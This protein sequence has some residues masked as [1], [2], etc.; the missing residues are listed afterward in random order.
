MT[1]SLSFIPPVFILQYT[2][3]NKT[4]AYIWSLS[5]SK[6]SRPQIS[7]GMG[8]MGAPLRALADLTPRTRRAKHTS[9]SINRS[10][11]RDELVAVSC[12]YFDLTQFTTCTPTVRRQN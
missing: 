6:P 8:S 2:R 3:D 4:R 7:D 11:I 1:H 5:S 12:K 10:I 9:F